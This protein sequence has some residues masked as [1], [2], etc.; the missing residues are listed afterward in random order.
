MTARSRILI[1]PTIA[2]GTLPDAERDVLR[3]FFVE[4]VRGMDSANDK[5]WR[6]FV[7]SLFNAEPG[8][9]FQLYLAEQRGGPYHRRHRAILQRLFD[10]QE[11]FRNIDRLH[12]WL[13]VG[14]GFVE[15][16]DGKPRP[17]ST[18]FDV[19]SEAEMREFHEAAIDYL[20]GERA[21][22]FLWRHVRAK[23][24]QGMLDAAINHNEQ[25]NT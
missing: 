7:R 1:C 2:L 15:W 25:E 21:Q 8:E 6:R 24:R 13:K 12:D 17:K 20:H 23:D 14:A 3:R 18:A 19:C 5:R 22:R 11:R 10:S 16:I 9:G 4:H